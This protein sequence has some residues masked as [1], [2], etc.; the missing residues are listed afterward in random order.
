MSRI[1]IGSGNGGTATIQANTLRDCTD[2]GIFLDTTGLGQVVSDNVLTDV[3]IP[4]RG[5]CIRT[6]PA[7]GG[8][9][10]SGNVVFSTA[11]R[12]QWT[13]Y[14]CAAGDLFQNNWRFGCGGT[15]GSAGPA[16]T[17]PPSPSDRSRGH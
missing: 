1:A 3:G 11:P 6:T 7:G 15:V 12:P 10:L 2:T 5:L 4:D 13:A 17:S 14:E 16:Q 8:V 9:V